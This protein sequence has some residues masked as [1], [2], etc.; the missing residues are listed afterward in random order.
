MTHLSFYWLPD[1]RHLLLKGLESEFAQMVEKA[2]SA[3]K[4]TLPPIPAVVLEVQQLCTNDST[5]VKQV[6]ECLIEDPS[7]VA[8]IIRVANSVVFNRRNIVCHDLQTAVSRL[9]I[10]RIRDIVTAQAIEQMKSQV[11]MREESRKVLAKS[12]IVSRELAGTMVMVTDAFKRIDP[13]RY[14]YLEPEK[15]LLVGLLA[16]IGLFCL[17][18]EFHLYLNQGN[19]L[20]PELAL[21]VFNSRCSDISQSVLQYWEFDTDYQEVASNTEIEEKLVE[22]SYL[23][24]ARIASYLLLYREQRK[25][26]E[27]HDMEINADGAEVVYDLCNLSDQDFKTQLREVIHSTDF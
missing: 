6:A 10:Y 20:D 14:A 24:I 26:L 1:N 7:L 3:G 5:T 4:I 8:V 25:P 19:Y 13:K 22:V 11:S 16:D 18:H 21:H 15:S 2:I 9:G 12:A 27:E 17:V 23:N